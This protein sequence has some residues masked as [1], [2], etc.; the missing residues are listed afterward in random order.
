M[1][2]VMTRARVMT[3]S[4]HDPKQNLGH[5]PTAV[6]TQP[7][8]IRLGHDPKNKLGHYRDPGLVKVPEY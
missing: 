5:D 6:M 8:M 3:G 2:R 1:T 4:G 7:V